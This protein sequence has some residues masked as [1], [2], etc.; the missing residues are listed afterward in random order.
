MHNLIEQL[1]GE[2]EGQELAIGDLN[3]VRSIGTR[4]S[5]GLKKATLRVGP[6]AE[7]QGF[8]L[9]YL[10]YPALPLSVRGHARGIV[11]GAKHACNVARCRSLLSPLLDRPTRLACEIDDIDVVPGDQDLAEMKVVVQTDLPAFGNLG[12]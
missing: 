4:R 6:P 2:E 12:Y 5:I 3:A 9:V 10:T 11:E 7:R 1:V 8:D